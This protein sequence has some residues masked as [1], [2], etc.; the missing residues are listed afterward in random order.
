MKIAYVASQK[1]FSRG[2]SSIEVL[3]LAEAMGR[4]GLDVELIIPGSSGDSD[5]F[6]YYGVNRSFKLKLIP[7]APGL[8]TRHIYHGLRSALYTYRKRAE[9]DLVLSR[10]IL[11]ALLASRVL[12]LPTIFDAHHPVDNPGSIAVLKLLKDAQNLIKFVAISEGI[13]DICVELGLPRKKLAIAPNAVDVERFNTDL[14]PR[15]ARK[16]LGLPEGKTIISHIGN[17][18]PGRGIEL[19]IEA[20]LELPDLLFLI[21]GGEQSDIDRYKQISL[22]R[23]ADNVEFTGFIPPGGVFKHFIATD[24]LILPYTSKM[25]TK[26]GRIETKVASLL[27]L[28]EYMASGRPIISTNIPAVTSALKDGVNSILIEPDSAGAIVSGIKNA[29]SDRGLCERIA[30]QAQNDSRGYSLE[31]RVATI[32]QDTGVS[33]TLSG[34][35]GIQEH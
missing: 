26:W 21:V 7:E 1:L 30:S 16:E 22:H 23:G 2:A 35:L 24:L 19:L 25:T 6:E 31:N 34:S 29:L 18:Y 27:K 28:S 14:A 12:N 4:A 20:A 9:Y 32:F 11:Y 15:D 33:L 3:R 10:N 8:S 17:I 13:G 5:I